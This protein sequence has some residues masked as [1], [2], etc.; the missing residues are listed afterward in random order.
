MKKNQDMKPFYKNLALWLVICLIMIMVFN[1]FN[2]PVANKNEISFSDFLEMVDSGRISA[3]T[4]Q[5]RNITGKAG[6]N[7]FKTYS[8]EDPTLVKTLR[9][10][11]IR[12]TAKPEDESPLWQSILIS[13]F[14]MLL[15][16]GVWIFFMRQMQAGGG[17]AMSFGK[18]RAKLLNEEQKKVT[19]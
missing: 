13:W 2:N 12:I 6:S 8:P 9:D 11:G 17:K 4:I 16:I 7:T 10:K 1:V 3:V 15:L 18:S 5:G 14:P 19:F